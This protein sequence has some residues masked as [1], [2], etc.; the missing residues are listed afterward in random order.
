[1]SNSYFFLPMAMN[2]NLVTFHLLTFSSHTFMPNVTNYIF[3]KNGT[4]YFS[5]KYLFC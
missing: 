1:M 5:K 2:N 4:C 3:Q